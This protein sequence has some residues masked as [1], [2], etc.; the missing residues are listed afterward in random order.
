MRVCVAGEI[1]PQHWQHCLRGEWYILTRHTQTQPDL[2]W[3][4]SRQHTPAPSGTPLPGVTQLSPLSHGL[5]DHTR[6]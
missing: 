2:P 1:R 5:L 6:L 4:S 3:L